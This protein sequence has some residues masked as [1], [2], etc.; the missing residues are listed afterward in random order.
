MVT[1]QGYHRAERTDQTDAAGVH[2]GS[3]EKGALEREAFERIKAQVLEPKPIRR[4]NLGE[5]N[6]L[7]RQRLSPLKFNSHT[8]CR[9][10]N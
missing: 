4:E 9:G 8:N 2:S 5:F 6:M 3:Q 10:Y 1:A 7:H